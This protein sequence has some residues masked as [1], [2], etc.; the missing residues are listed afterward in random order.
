[1]GRRE[2]KEEKRVGKGE[3]GYLDIC[4]A[5]RVSSFA[6]DHSCACPRSTY[7]ALFA[8]GQQQR[9]GLSLPVL[10]LSVPS[11]HR[12]HHSSHPYSFIPRLK[13]SFSANPS[14]RSLPFL[15]QD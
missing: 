6:T 2:R 5:P 12:S 11:T 14:H 4:P 1:M 13:P 8:M 3:N 15:L 7:S 10:L 9:C